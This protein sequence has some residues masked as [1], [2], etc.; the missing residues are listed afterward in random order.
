MQVYVVE[1]YCEDTGTWSAKG[2]YT[3]YEAAEAAAE[4]LDGARFSQFF[5]DAPPVVETFPSLRPYHVKLDRDLNVL[6]VALFSKNSFAPPKPGFKAFEFF[7]RNKADAVRIA[8]EEAVKLI[9]SGEWGA[10]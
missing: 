1:A 8:K 3:T 7:A 5:I 4:L 10:A 9:E 6:E 2:V